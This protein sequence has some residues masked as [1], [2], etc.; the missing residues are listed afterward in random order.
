MVWPALI[1]AGATLAGGILQNNSAKAQA[2]RQMEFQEEMSN[3][4][5][6]RG[7]EDMRQAGLNPILAAKVGGA[8]TPSG[9]AAP[10]ANVVGPA[11]SSAL[12]VQ[13]QSA[14]IANTEALTK[15]TQE[16]TKSIQYN[17]EA[18]QPKRSTEAALWNLGSQSAK[19]IDRV[20]EA[21]RDFIQS[22][23]IKRAV[24]ASSTADFSGVRA[25]NQSG[26]V[27][28]SA[29]S[30]RTRPELGIHS[31]RMPAGWVLGPNGWPTKV[32][33]TNPFN[34]PPGVLMPPR[35]R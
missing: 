12:Q 19:G 24:R 15:K 16:E 7:M 17:N 2:N 29:N 21:T 6:Q 9:A 34:F 14:Q 10:V 25:L 11:V 18:L 20:G 1:A 30:V 22:N 32:S 27:G 28:S 31:P 4:S 3:T 35:S 23:P 26:F 13:Q 33:D 8:T 5:Y